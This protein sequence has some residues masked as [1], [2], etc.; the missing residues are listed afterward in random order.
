MGEHMVPMMSQHHHLSDQMVYDILSR[1]PV[2]SII[3]FRYVSKSWNSI[4]TDPYFKLNQAKSLSN[5]SHN[6]YVI[7]TKYPQ[8]YIPCLQ[9]PQ[10]KVEDLCTVVCNS[11]NTL[12]EVSRIEIPCLYEPIVGF[13]NGLFILA[14]PSPMEH[15]FQHIYL[16]NPIIRKFM[17]VA[18]ILGQ[19]STSSVT[20]GFAYH[21]RKNDF[22]ILRL[23]CFKNEGKLLPAKAE[24][25]A[26][27]YTLS[28]ASWR[29]FSVSVDSLSGLTIY[30][31]SESPSLFFNGALHSIAF[32]RDYKFILS[33]DVDDERFREIRLP[34]NYLVGVSLRREWLT[35]L[36]GSLALIV[37]G[38]A[39]ID[40]SGVCHIWV[41]TEY[42]VAKS[43]TKKCVPMDK[44]AKFLS[45][46]IN[47]ELL[48]R[49]YDLKVRIVSFDPESLKEEVLR[50]PDPRDV[51]YTT[52]FVE[53][54][55]LLDGLS[56]ESYSLG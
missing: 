31:I 7:Y 23:V 14:S 8:K 19:P 33:F 10:H 21:P 25:E 52:N 34:Q 29:K 27:V 12:T 49:R 44:H 17:R 20:L 24:A 43:W 2:K 1:L 48:I 28:T 53:S 37:I 51:I 46:T 54:L 50:I 36:K 32:T 18:S 11:D 41:M 45:C 16:W 40:W 39:Q 9:Y 55:V 42:G 5:N 56:N 22:K 13:C 6:G 4:V 47:G 38:D 30:R 26:E 35:I 15:S 3:R